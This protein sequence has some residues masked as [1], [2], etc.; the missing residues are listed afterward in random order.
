MLLLVLNKNSLLGNFTLILQNFKSYINPYGSTFRFR[1]QSNRY[2][3]Q[4]YHK[5]NL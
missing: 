5:T 1:Q 2:I 4:T 3:T